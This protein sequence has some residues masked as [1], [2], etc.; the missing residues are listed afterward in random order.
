MPE[1]E[2]DPATHELFN[3]LV[4]QSDRVTMTKDAAQI[5]NVTMGMTGREVN[6]RL[7]RIELELSR[8]NEVKDQLIRLKQVTKSTLFAI[9]KDDD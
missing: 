9:S 6:A 4:D 5:A 7:N 3:E 1:Q 2:V 8:L